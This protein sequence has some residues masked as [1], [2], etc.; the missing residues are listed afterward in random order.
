MCIIGGLYLVFAPTDWRRRE[1]S[2]TNWLEMKDAL[3]RNYFPPT[4]RSFLLKEWDHL[5]QGTAPVAKYVEKFK[6]FKRWIQIVEEEV[7]TFNR[8]KKGL[9]ANL[10]CEIIT[11]GVTTLRE[12]YDL[13][14]NCELASKSIFWQHFELRSVLTNPQPFGSKS[15]LALPP[16]VNPDSTP[17]EKKD[18]GK[19][20]VNEPSRLGYRLQCFKCNGVGHIANRC[21]SRTFVI[22]EDYEKIEDV[23]ELV[24]NPRGVHGLG[25]VG[26]RGFFDPTHHGG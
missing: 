16:K 19:G 11:K 23:V 24:Y 10:L 13:S 9:N 4:Y 3:S 15:R 1:P 5:K 26:L 7:V 22:Q 12:A 8:F 18:K 25:W 17:I 2:I 14:R 6:E 20:V 21:P